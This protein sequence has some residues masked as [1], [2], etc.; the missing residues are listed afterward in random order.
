M[1][2]MVLVKAFEANQFWLIYHRDK[3]LAQ[4]VFERW[5]ALGFRSYLSQKLILT[6]G[7][8]KRQPY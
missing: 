2:L 1:P 7:K 3:H 6:K 4:V 5:T 8:S